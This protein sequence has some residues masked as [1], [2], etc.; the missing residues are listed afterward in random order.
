M[1]NFCTKLI[2][3]KKDLKK[4]KKS[5]LSSNST[6]S[7]FSRFQISAA[8]S[9]SDFFKTIIPNKDTSE[10]KLTKRTSPLNSSYL[11]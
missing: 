4:K 9:N 7:N 6:Y 5:K 3:E 11:N 2:Q 10:W 8:T 1:L